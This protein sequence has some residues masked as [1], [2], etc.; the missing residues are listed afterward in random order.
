MSDI[1]VNI[2]GNAPVAMP[3]GVTVRDALAGLQSNKQRK[4]TVA[5]LIDGELFDFTTV[6]EKDTEISPVQIGSDEALEVLRHSAAHVMAHAVRDL[7][8]P[9]VKIAIGPA[10]ENG[11][12]Y[13]FQRTEPF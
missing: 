5:A 6:L 4:Q 2:P 11:F 12:Y 8:G 7:F 10:I 9:D 1:L 13:D 3:A